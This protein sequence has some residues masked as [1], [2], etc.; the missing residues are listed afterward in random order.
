MLRQLTDKAHFEWFRFMPVTRDMSA[1]ARAL[2]YAF[3]DGAG[4][5]AAAIEAAAR[6]KAAPSLRRLSRAMRGGGG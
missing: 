5:P 1:G 2:L 6:E 4:V 3:L